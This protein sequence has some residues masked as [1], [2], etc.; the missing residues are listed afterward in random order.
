M[1]IPLIDLRAQYRSIKPEIDEAFQRVVAGG[2]F[3]LGPEVEALEREVAAYCG[4]RHGVGVA[5]G[6]DALELALR[7]C[8]IGS[9]DEVITS[10]FSF[11]AAAE[12]VATVGATPVLVD[13]D[14]RTFTMDPAQA[15]AAV[16]PKTKA[17]IPVHLFGHPCDMDAILDLAHRQHHLVIEDCAQA[18]GARYGGRRVGGLGR[19][20]ILSFYPSKNLGAYGDGGMVVTNDEGLSERI[21][22]LRGHGSRAR[23]HHE[24][25][26]RNSRLDELQ[27]AVLRVKLRHL[28]DW[29]AAR[30]RHAQAYAEAFARHGLTQVSLPQEGASCEHV[31]HLYTVRLMDRD[32]VQR[33]LDAEGVATQAAYPSILPDQP[34]LAPHV[35]A[36]GS[37]PQ[38]RQAAEEVLSLPMYPELTAPQIDDVVRGLASVIQRRD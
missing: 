28:D 34:A 5:S 23:Y 25:L 13:I 32:R 30:R 1:E 29:N 7:A 38:A 35:K 20:A 8:G 24:L 21:R 11:V 10:A 15:A 14:A 36:D 12:A 9:G 19:A 3:I 2:Q 31:Y 33:A 27:A 18:L 26:G 17:I 37:F 6:T 16:T 22:L 4:T